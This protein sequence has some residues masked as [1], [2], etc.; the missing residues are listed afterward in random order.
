[1]NKRKKCRL[2]K[3]K[4]RVGLY[5]IF[6]SKKVFHLKSL[7]QRRNKTQYDR[8]KD[9]SYHKNQQKKRNWT[10]NHFPNTLKIKQP[11]RTTPKNAPCST[12]EKPQK[13]VHSSPWESF[14]AAP[15]VNFPNFGLLSTIFAC[16]I[17]RAT[18]NRPFS[19]TSRCPLL[20][21]VSSLI[22]AQELPPVVPKDVKTVKIACCGA[23]CE[24]TELTEPGALGWGLRTVEVSDQLQTITNQFLRK[25]QSKEIIHRQDITKDIENHPV[26]RVNLAKRTFQTPKIPWTGNLGLD[27]N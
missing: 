6:L 4:T 17:G 5:P 11:P 20:G 2:R 9:R 3:P 24:E 16:V 27:S 26:H 18:S 23:F 22:T 12:L 14:F 21:L 19:P 13:T 25:L 1:M 15:K 10:K 8:I 7:L